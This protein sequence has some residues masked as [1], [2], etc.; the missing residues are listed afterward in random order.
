M[1]FTEHQPTKEV[2]HG[3][4]PPITVAFFHVVV[5]YEL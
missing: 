4:L 5:V 1:L 2:L 3:I